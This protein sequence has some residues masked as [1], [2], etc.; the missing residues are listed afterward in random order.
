MSTAV[1]SPSATSLFSPRWRNLTIGSIGLCFMMAFEAMGVAAGM[2]A[3][4]KSLDGMNLYALAFASTMAGSLLA[5]VWSGLDCDRNGPFPSMAGGLLLFAAGL[6]LAGLAKSMHV[7]IF[8]RI[9]QG[10]GIGALGVALYV[11]AARALQSA[12]LPRLFAMFSSAW[13]VPALIGPAISG[14]VVEVL[15]WRWLFLGTFLLLLPAAALILPSL[16]RASE[17]PAERKARKP[18]SI[19]IWALLAASSCVV[20]SVSGI[21][22][23]WAHLTVVITLAVLLT[24]ADRLLPIGTLRLAPGLPTVIA[25]R[26]LYASAFFLCEAFVPLW[27]HLERGWSIG[28]AGFALTGGALSWSAGSHLQSRITDEARRRAWLSYGGLLLCAGIIVSGLTVMKLFPDWVLLIGWSISG[29]GAGLSLPMLGVLT[30]T[31]SPREQQ[32]TY[33]SA[34]QLSAAMCTSAALAGGGVLFSS[35]Q[36]Q[37]P[38]LAYISVF[39]L[40]FL[41]ASL[42]HICVP[43][44]FS[45][46]AG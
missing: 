34:L 24:S 44:A 5:M 3:V 38:L 40:A 31:L 32:G 9:V 27:L 16:H 12:L 23:S 4:A 26:G 19:L 20:L 7:L 13:V 29:L 46:P 15:G 8:G 18:E 35:L 10:L 42:A 17:D 22:G 33:S 25:L 36:G 21:A 41:L 45:R 30:L 14:Y 43:R 28:T 1:D 6:L 11:A 2:P 37:S 39:V